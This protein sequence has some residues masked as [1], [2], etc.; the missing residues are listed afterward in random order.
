[1]NKEIANFHIDY[2]IK[3]I[4]N[5]INISYLGKVFASLLNISDE[6]L[7]KISKQKLKLKIMNSDELEKLEKK[8]N[9][10]NKYGGCFQQTY[11]TY[12][13]ETVY[14]D[15]K[16]ENV[17]YLGKSFAGLLNISD[18]ELS[19]LSKEELKAKIRQFKIKTI[20][21]EA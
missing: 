8:F 7:Y 5:Q 2:L 11:S 3:S 12:S 19:K 14:K 18:E 6:E 15:T 4:S 17:D 10:L 13:N 16:Q 1:M 20:F 9:N 21:D